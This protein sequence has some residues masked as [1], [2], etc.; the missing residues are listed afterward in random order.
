[1]KLIFRIIAIIILTIVVQ[2][3]M[4]NAQ[5]YNILESNDQH[6]ILEFNYQNQFE[7]EDFYL[8]G[9]KFTRILDN[10]TPVR[11]PGTPFL[12]TR[13]YNIG[14]PMGANCRVT[15]LE[16]DKELLKD[17]FVISTPDSMDQP[18]RLLHFNQDVYGI[19]SPFP[20]EIAEINSEGIYRYIKLS[21]LV[22]SPYQYNPVERIL[23]FNKRFKI[24]IDY[25][26]DKNSV[27]SFEPVI[28]KTTRDYIDKYVVNPVQSL[29][30]ISKSV[31]AVDSPA[32]EYW[33]N[34]NKNYYKIF[35]NK[36]GVYRVTYD[37]LIAAGI[38][39]SSGIQ[40]GRLEIIN[41]GVSIP[42]DI[43]DIQ[44]DGIFN[45]GDY[46]QFVGKT[47]SPQDNYTRMNIY[48]LSNVYWFSYQADSVLSYKYIDGFPHGYSPLIT[49]T[50]KTILWEE[51]W[52]Y[53]HFGHAPNDQ[54]DYWMWD[55]T[56]S[57]NF[58]PYHNFLYWIQDSI[59]NDFV[60]DR[61]QATIK[62]GVHGLTSTS[63]SSGDGHNINIKFNT[64]ILGNKSW[65][66]QESEIFETDFLLAYNTTGGG[67]TAKLNWQDL[68]KFEVECN[69][70]TCVD[71]DM[72][73][74]NYF[75]L[76]YWA[77]NKTQENHFY[78]TSPPNNFNDNMYYLWLWQRN[79]MKI[80]IPGRNEIISNPDI[81][82]DFD[83]SVY[84]IDTIHTQTEYF[85]VADDYF[86]KVDS[87]TQD[88]NSD[89]RNTSNGADYIIITHQKFLSAAEQLAAFRNNNIAG[90]EN[91]R[92]KVVEIQD[93]YD[94]FSYGL[95]NPFALKDFVKYAFYNWQ[96]PSAQYVVLI[97]DM[98]YDYRKIF[99]SSRDNFIPSI[100]FH[101]T[102]YGQAPS[103]NAIVTVS[104][105]DLIPELAIGRI[106]CETVEE[107]SSLIN[108]I[109]NY[110]GDQSKEWKQNVL[111][112][113]SGLS[114]ED[115]NQLKFNDKNVWLENAYMK[116]FGIHA[117]KIFRYPNK[118]EYIPFQG[119]GP[120]IRREIDNGA[121]IANYYGHG[122]GLQ[123]DLVF[124]NDDIY[125][126]NNGNR[127][128]FI[129]SITCYTAHFDN[130]EIFGE[131]F[132][133]IPN[134]GSIAFWGSSGVTFW[135]TT[136][137]INE[138]L[139]ADI[140]INKDYVIGNAINIAKASQIAGSMTSVLT[141]L[142]DPAIELALPYYPDFVIKQSNIS[143]SPF[144]PLVND[145]V[146]VKIIINNV[147]RT[148][149]G[150]S[151]TVNL[152]EN[153][154]SDTTLIGTNKL[155]SFG[156]IDST[157]FVWYPK[158]SGLIDIIASINTDHTIIEEDFSDNQSSASFSVFDFG[159]PNI[160]KPIDGY[161][162]S[163]DS[164]QF[165]ISDIG[166]Y[167]NLDFNYVIQICNTPDFSANNII[168]QSNSLKAKDA[169]VSFEINNLNPGEYFWRAIIFDQLDTN[170]SKTRTF[171]IT[172]S[173]D[174]LGYLAKNKLLKM[175]NTYNI[176]YSEDNGSLIL[177]TELKP[178]HPSP[179]FLID[180]VYYQLPSDSTKPSMFTTDGSYFYITDFPVF[181]SDSSSKIYKIGT[182]YGGTNLGENYGSVPNLSLYINGNI[183]SYNDK[184][185]ANTGEVNSILRID[186]LSGDTNK[187]FIQDSLLVSLETSTQ[188]GGVYMYSDGVYVYNLGIGTNKY[189]NK[190]VL[191]TFNPD[192]NWAKVG[193]DLILSGS[194]IRRIASF[195][196]VQGY[197]IVYENYNGYSLR[198]YRLSDGAF[199]EEWRYSV[200]AKDYYCIAYDRINNFV[201][202]Q[203]FRPGTIPYT[204]AF[205]KYHGTY[206]EANG[207]VSSPEIGPSAHWNRLDYVIEKTNSNGVFNS[208]LYGKQKSNGNWVLL[209]TTFTSG[210]DLSDLTDGQY[211][212]LKVKFE[213][214]DSSFGAGETMKFKSLKVL[215]TPLAE[216][217]IIPKDFNFNPDTVLQGIPVNM[218]L[219]L[220]NIGYSD[221]D[222]LKIDF[223]DNISDSV[224]YS[225]SISLPLNNL[226]TVSKIINSDNLLYTAP[227]SPVQV[228]V[229][230]RSL[231]DE[232]FTFNNKAL[233]SF[234]VTRDSIQPEFKIT[235]DG[236][237]LVDGDVIS[238]KPEVIMTLEDNSPLP[239]T[240]NLFT[241]VLDNVHTLNFYNP[242]D[243]L[244]FDYIPYPNSKATVTWHPKLEDGTHSLSVFVKDSS[245]NPFNSAQ[246]VYRFNVFNN[247]DLLQVYNYPN[248]FKDKT[249]FTFELRGVIPPEEVKIK[250]FTVAG[251][252][253]KEMTIPGSGLQIGFNRIPWDGTDQD[254]DEIANGVYFYKIISKHG[255]K[256]M[257][258]TQKL[259][260]LK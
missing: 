57:R 10:T 49:S 36:K 235:F 133:S 152:Y 260:K 63:C 100:P 88:K 238:S 171:S 108:K 258:T 184:L 39:P 67:D 170:Y 53:Q 179:K 242:T 187:I 243:S 253:I 78:F 250:V 130:Q 247:P 96:T 122:G 192:N 207:E 51:D 102:T 2:S 154:V 206:I 194:T 6:I 186:P 151:V 116:P 55:Y 76:Q 196:V 146:E 169:I 30:F 18:Y 149:P 20:S 87:L 73:L 71:N 182:G 59:W 204:P 165:L 35:L 226:V 15:L 11:D 114:A 136:A 177:N 43:I 175:F 95:L 126:L 197:L 172:D 178:P 42:I 7:V 205:F 153:L 168:F 189:P 190:F 105:D 160:I 140:F 115:E 48:N 236:K 222:S 92:I 125:E 220:K 66:G 123:W 32:E 106:S 237:E 233:N 17:K 70:N 69:G 241:L 252:L 84:F 21:S 127:L 83:H 176:N 89:L 164:I 208:Y 216:V 4:L 62:V 161:F 68:Q 239:I 104:G 119:E 203:T 97:G 50:Q 180:S 26:T 131:I 232:F 244:K 217:S 211:N 29:N 155:G 85:C 231:P 1:M 185:F 134:K 254:G 173:V 148:F 223:Y 139:F 137:N 201:Y 54:R 99:S 188:I 240:S 218:T 214:A 41:D 5:D 213:L 246:S 221:I 129:S 256:T 225:T 158:K 19:N 22:V 120:D 103:D 113:S 9:I 219:N 46:F 101:I 3:Q 81:K 24:R 224:F 234:Y 162:T 128:P 110:P 249:E 121:V 90:I 58:L 124:T 141:L 86:L 13:F 212:F 14:I 61:P 229:T 56:E 138:K 117:T 64:K 245:G 215:Y 156:E 37:Q 47:P 82:N 145:S 27:K 209:D 135:P 34:P 166:F 255:D 45:S 91:P 230:A 183:F 112:M 210:Y 143:I 44:D 132:N 40:D 16:T 257:V 111:L 142:G 248:P 31:N 227:V 191:R 38:S 159:E 33:Y 251:R 259:A 28:D 65:D 74:I 94:E 98:S 72:V 118:P 200:K 228:T 198:S 23:I 193:E 157:I 109:L 77:W 195:I 25:V 163:T 8:N 167:F 12:P 107:A 60:E 174:G 147:G 199:E 144:H 75:Q 181:T 52:S 150:D 202:F 93:I 79:N 80:Y